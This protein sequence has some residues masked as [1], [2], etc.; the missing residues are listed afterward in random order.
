M[1]I[2]KQNIRECLYLRK[3]AGGYKCLKTWSG[4][5]LKWEYCSDF[6]Q[7]KHKPIKPKT[8]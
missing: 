5:S 4:C 1:S 3:V 7:D 6:K 2:V 8:K